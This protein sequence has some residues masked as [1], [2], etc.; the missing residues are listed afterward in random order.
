MSKVLVVGGGAAGMAAALSAAREGADVLLLEHNEKLGKKVYITGKGRCNVTN[1]CAVE[2]LFSHAVSNPK[3]LMGAFHK[4]TNRDLMELLEQNGCPLAV[5]RGNRVFPASMH[6]SDVIRCFE[7]MLLD[8]GVLIRLN[9]EV[10]ALRA[11]DGR[12]STVSL[13]KEEL[14]PDAV[15]LATGGMSYPSTGSRGDGY[16]FARALGHTVTAL[17]PS[18][19]SLDAR[20][21]W[22][23]DL[24][25]L[26]LKNVSVKALD[27][28][29]RKIREEEGELLFTHKGVSGPTVLRISAYV[30]RILHEGGE[31]LLSLDLKPALTEDVLDE[32]LLREL[33]EA[34]TKT[35]KNVMPNLAPKSLGRVILMKAGIPEETRAS[36]VRRED[37]QALLKALKELTLH[38]TGTGG[39]DE[40][41]V[42]QGGI[43]VREIEPATMK[44]KLYDN[45]FFAGEMIDTD[46]MT[47]GFSLQQAWST[48]WLAG[49][50][51]AKLPSGS[52]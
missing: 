2:D 40:A 29:G 30:T 52:R 9:T 26:T 31:I 21:Q 3:F 8:A 6:A 39:F 7:R 43:S 46:L 14:T 33:K 19:V 44:S 32:R 25:G 20:E 17:Y 16:R 51:A 5:E 42:T 48:G 45:L 13:G 4:F 35:L 27:S 49:R 41:I 11:A 23:S 28:E 37:R 1:A 36:D 22:C 38:I 50:S 24:S 10:R 47:G 15:V 18:L 34:G 12:I